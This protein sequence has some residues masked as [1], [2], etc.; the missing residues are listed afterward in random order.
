[1][2]NAWAREASLALADGR[3]LSFVEPPPRRLSALAY[4]RRIAERAEIVTRAG[5]LHD[6]CNALAW[7]LFPRTKAALN[8]IHVDALRPRRPQHRGSARDAATLLD[9]SG[10]LFACVDAKLL[11]Q[12]RAH[13]WRE[14]FWD[15][16]EADALPARALVIGHGLLAKCVAPFRAITARALVLPRAAVDLPLEF[17]ELS[18]AL[19]AVAAAHLAA[20]GASFEPQ[21]L[22]PL[23]IAALPGW[24]TAHLGLRLFDDVTVFRPRRSRNRPPADLVLR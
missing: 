15:R 17:P 20:L 21:T 4:E 5:S 12:W 2:L 16:R 18:A 24:D 3:P 6:F 13:A 8:A 22:L 11:D 19:D 23:P 7:L 9:E 1:M 10:V 14:A